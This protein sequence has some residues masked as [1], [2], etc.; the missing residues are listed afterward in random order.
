MPDYSKTQMYKLKCIDLNVTEIYVGHTTNFKMRKFGHKS[1]CYNKQSESYNLY[2]YQFIRE[3]G[4]WDN[5][6]M[7]WIEDY[8]CANRTQAC[9]REGELFKELKATLNMDMPGRT[10]KE[11]RLLI[12]GTEKEKL[13]LKTMYESNREEFKIRFKKRY[14]KNKDIRVICKICGVNILKNG[15]LRHTQRKHL[16]T[17]KVA[18]AVCDI[19]GLELNRDSLKRHIKLVHGS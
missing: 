11:Y 15:L 4:G 14:E 19:C 3:N 2:V 16:N 9:R 7:E 6:N 18:R 8:P 10:K 1:D 12:A 17:Y 5:F 13:R